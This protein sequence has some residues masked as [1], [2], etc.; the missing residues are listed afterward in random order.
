MKKTILI[1]LLLLFG[2]SFSSLPTANAYDVYS[3]TCATKQNGASASVGQSPVCNKNETTGS[4]P[5]TGSKGVIIKV[6]R[7]IAVITG[8]AAVIMIIIGGI[9]F[10]VSGGEANS[11]ATAKNTILYALIG[12]VVILISSTLIA[13]VVD[14]I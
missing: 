8:V 9:E 5:I 13:F 1:S 7:I 14:R 11:V 4:N 12:L 6:T 10:V 3:T 2:L